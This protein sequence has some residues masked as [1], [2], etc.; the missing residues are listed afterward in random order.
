M[1]H[2]LS[3]TRISSTKLDVVLSSSSSSVSEELHT[4]I[5]AKLSSTS[6]PSISSAVLLILLCCVTPL[7]CV[8]SFCW[9]VC[10]Q[11]N[12]IHKSTQ[13]DAY[14]C[15]Y[16]SRTEKPVG[17]NII[18]ANPSVYWPSAIMW[19]SI[20]LA[21]FYYHLYCTIW[22]ASCNF[23]CTSFFI[24]IKKK[25]KQILPI[26][27]KMFQEGD[28]YEI[29]R[30]AAISQSTPLKLSELVG[31]IHSTCRSGYITLT[32]ASIA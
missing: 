21:A 12:S 28:A 14:T 30:N 10:V 24:H 16:A 29:W 3:S 26:T 1:W 11:E 6:P 4:S 13:I 31:S 25:S 18:P 23:W 27:D 7:V 32:H 19:A 2:A 22:N 5:T 20:H 8:A 17:V 9:P 15:V